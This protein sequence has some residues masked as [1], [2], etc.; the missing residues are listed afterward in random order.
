MLLDRTITCPVLVG[1]T[2]SMA[3]FGSVLERARA[4]EGATVLVSGEAGVGKSRLLRAAAEQ[5]RAE[6]FLVLQGAGFEADRALPFA[7]LLDLVRGF[8]AGTSSA[9]AA[10]ALSPAGPELLALFP[11]LGW[12]FTD[13]VPAPPRDP[14]HGRRRL[15]HALLQAVVLL[16]R[17]QPLFLVVE[18]VHWSDDATL[19]LLDHLARGIRDDPVVLALSYRSD[20]V[21][22][23]LE[24]LLA[25]HD[26]ARRGPELPLARL[27]TDG[28]ATMLQAIFGAD[29][30]PGEQFTG[31]LYGLT[32]LLRDALDNPDDWQVLVRC[33]R[34][35]RNSDGTKTVWMEKA[36]D[37]SGKR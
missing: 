11:E 5:A 12:V 28:V 21:G 33:V 35:D 14:E 4:G 3:V 2:A 25:E 17:R 16:A 27:G 7:P 19:D 9:V 6:G 30:A 20:E 18:D 23:R 29:A 31:M 10:H 8:A 13:V 36:D 32:E 24:R 34:I 26:R 1:R 15:F 22:P 37:R